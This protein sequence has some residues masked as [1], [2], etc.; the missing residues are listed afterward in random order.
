MNWGVVGGGMLGLALAER[1]AMRGDSVTVYEAADHF[2]GLA[3]PWRLGDIVWDRHYHV[4]LASDI[5]LRAL[6]R[7]LDIE[8][9]VVWRKTRTGAFVKGRLHGASN[10]LEFLCLPA[11]SLVDKARIVTTMF[12]AS[13]TPKNVLDGQTAETW[14]RRWS[15]DGGYQ[16]FWEPLLRSK[17]GEDHHCASAS[18]IGATIE[19]LS[20]ARRNEFGEE[21]FGY[22]PGGYAVVLARYEERLRALG[23]ELRANAQVHEI[24]RAGNGCEIRS[25][26]G[27]AHVDRVVATV[28]A[29][30]AARMCP[31]LGVEERARLNGLRYQGIVCAAI[32][33]SRPLS[34]YYVTNLIDPIFPFT[35]VV[36]MTALVDPVQFGGNALVYLPKYVAPND[37]IFEEDDAQTQSR[38]LAGLRHIHPD[39]RDEEI[40]AFR[41]SRV[42][43][44]FT[45]PTVGYNANV[46]PM[47]TSLPGLVLVNGAQITGG[48]LNVNETL[49]L[50]ERAFAYITQEGL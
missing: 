24:R 12:A 2:G 49:A 18:F 17:L 38:F 31:Q 5:A 43:H 22:V 21:R 35:G 9:E 41:I 15:G 42:R 30:F 1:L 20:S 13:R 8:K 10:G 37:P 32:L 3:A 14:L 45:I 33:L 27:V 4:T 39:L 29:P 34:P 28:P 50:A 23:V 19:R 48:T 16:R 40:R 25:S 7:R 47:R 44:V 6:L 36:E 46:P 11:L 26:L